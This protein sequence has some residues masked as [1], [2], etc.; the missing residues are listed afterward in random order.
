MESTKKSKLEAGE[1]L[2]NR[3]R[4]RIIS[5][6]G[7]NR[8]VAQTYDFAKFSKKMHETEKK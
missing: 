4:S 6:R 7:A 5:S 1:K 3:G 2:V 8:L